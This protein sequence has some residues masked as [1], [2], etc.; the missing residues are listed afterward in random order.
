VGDCKVQAVV[1]AFLARSRS[2]PIDINIEEEYLDDA[3][4]NMSR[5]IHHVHRWCT[6][7]ISAES[8]DGEWKDIISRLRHLCAP[9]LED[10]QLSLMDDNHDRQDMQLFFTFSGGTP[11]LR[12]LDVTTEALYFPSQRNTLTR[13]SLH[14]LPG[15]SQ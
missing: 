6:L 8:S 12:T 4:R 14:T 15:E 13:L 11:S 1:D 3:L 10:F 5:L 7:H 2:C 9:N